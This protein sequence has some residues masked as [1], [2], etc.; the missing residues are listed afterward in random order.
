MGAFF[1]KQWLDFKDLTKALL[2]ENKTMNKL[3]IFLFE[4]KQPPQSDRY[5]ATGKKRI[6]LSRGGGGGWGSV[7][8]MYSVINVGS[9]TLKVAARLLSQLC[10][11]VLGDSVC[12]GCR[13][14]LEL[15]I[16]KNRKTKT[17]QF[18]FMNQTNEQNNQKKKEASVW[19]FMSRFDGSLSLL[20]LSL[21]S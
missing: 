18:H 17:P 9:S 15:G 1:R 2:Q 11:V 21:I 4:P 5:P 6:P 3:F 12:C 10:A 19:V 7:L 16:P 20:L 14:I 13:H 8:W